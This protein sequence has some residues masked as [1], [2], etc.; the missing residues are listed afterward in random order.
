MKNNSKKI[1]ITGGAGF[2]GSHVADAFSKAGYKV[3]IFD[4]KESS[5]IRK[6]QKFIKGD[7][8][9]EKLVNKSLKG[10]YGVLHF[11]GASDIDDSNKRPLETIKYNILGT[12]NILEACVK[13]KVSRFIFASSIYVYSDHGGFYRST[14]QSSELLIENYHKLKKQNFTI[15]RFGSLYGRRANKFNWINN[16]IYQAL[17]KNKMERHGSGDEIRDYIHVFDAAKACVS[18]LDKKFQNKY[19]ILKGTQTIKIKDLMKMINEIIDKKI[20]IKYLP[21]KDEEHY[22]I[23]PY[24]FRPR[25]AIRYTENT[26][27]DLGEGILDTVYEVYKNIYGKNFQSSNKN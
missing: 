18:I 15:L 5:W 27:M 8:L 13:S 12:S 17:K 22:E 23:T 3:I 24:S 16:I 4:K 11:A 25:T 2:L 14:K 20:Q 10:I 6:D 26:Q 21:K 19:V 9:D 7:I 1:L